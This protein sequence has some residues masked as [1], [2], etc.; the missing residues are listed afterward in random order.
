[1]SWDIESHAMQATNRE[2][3]PRATEQVSTITFHSEERANLADFSGWGKS[4]H[5]CCWYR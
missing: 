5:R 3:K 4:S 1:M 2:Q